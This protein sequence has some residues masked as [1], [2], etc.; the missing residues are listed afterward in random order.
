MKLVI[1]QPMYFPWV[2]LLEQV[3]IADRFVHYDDVQL[4]RGFYNRVQVKTNGGSKWM[5]VPLRDAHRGQ[6][7]NEVEADEREDWRGKHR[8][9]LKQ[10][11][12]GAPFIGD[13]LDVVDQVFSQ[14]LPHLAAISRAS[15]MAIADYFGLTESRVFFDSSLLCIPGKSSQRLFDICQHLRATTYVTGH[16]AK[17]YLDHALFE[18]GGIAVEYM[19]YSC[20]PYQQ[21][22][23]T[24]TPYVSGL[25]LI[26]NCGHDGLKY[27]NPSTSPWKEIFD[28]P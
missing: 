1:S 28:E 20:L 16:G 12:A 8:H 7:L 10:A 18:R 6:L 21:L 26:A 15:T 2:G 19:D 3:R 22:H 13:M 11:Y 24:F 27:I 25:D 17:N 9:L 5:T 23:G 14:A 4:A